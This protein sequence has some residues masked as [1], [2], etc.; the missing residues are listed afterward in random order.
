V[1][2]DNVLAF[3]LSDSPRINQ[4]TALLVCQRDVDE[5]D[6]ASDDVDEDLTDDTIEE[7]IDDAGDDSGDDAEADLQ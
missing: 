5:G 2:E 3:T 6:D 7:P 4:K 1:L